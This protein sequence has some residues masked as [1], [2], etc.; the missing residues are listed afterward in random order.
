MRMAIRLV[1]LLVHGWCTACGMPQ[2]LS[3]A[4]KHEETMLH[5]KQKPCVRRC[6]RRGP[7][8]LKRERP[9]WC[10][11]Q[12]VCQT[13]RALSQG[14][15]SKR[16]KQVNQ[17]CQC[18]CESRRRISNLGK[19]V[20]IKCHSKVQLSDALLAGTHQQFRKLVWRSLWWCLCGVWMSDS[21]FNH[22][23]STLACP[24]CGWASAFRCWPGPTNDLESWCGAYF[25]DFFGGNMVWMSEI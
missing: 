6:R 20:E 2:R 1:W 19:C 24:F 16:F 11:L 12:I 17:S 10:G 3:S 5:E 7:C 23:H 14:K 4:P 18:H 22:C 9:L 25:D 8:V 21:E 15:W 13:R